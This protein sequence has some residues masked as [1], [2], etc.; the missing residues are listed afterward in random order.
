[1]AATFFSQSAPPLWTHDNKSQTTYFGPQEE[2]V[3]ITDW[4]VTKSVCR[5]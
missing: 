4:E 5:L 2:F 1:M 3:R